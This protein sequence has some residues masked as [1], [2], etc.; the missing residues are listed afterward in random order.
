MNLGESKQEQERAVP[1][2]RKNGKDTISHDISSY[3]HLQVPLTS[4]PKTTIRSFSNSLLQ[5][6]T[7]N[8]KLGAIQTPTLGLLDE[9][10]YTLF[11]GFT[12]FHGFLGGIRFFSNHSSQEIPTE[13]PTVPIIELPKLVCSQGVSF[14]PKNTRSNTNTGDGFRGGFLRWT[15]FGFSQ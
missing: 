7:K 15:F 14:R 12:C 1:N 10:R 8:R 6:Q 11:K 13:R 4:S 3:H 9:N 2:S 5:T